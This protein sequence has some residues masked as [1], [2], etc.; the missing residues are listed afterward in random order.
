MKPSYLVYCLDFDR[1]SVYCLVREIDDI[2]Q[3]RKNKIR[4]VAIEEK[5]NLPYVTSE[6]KVKYAQYQQEIHDKIK[7][8]QK[9]YFPQRYA[10]IYLLGGD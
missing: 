9:K 6:Q 10:E 7:E 3:M 5:R 1:Q 8:Y 2:N 4:I